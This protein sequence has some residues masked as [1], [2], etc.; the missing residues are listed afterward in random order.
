MFILIHYRKRMFL[1][2]KILFIKTKKD[3]TKKFGF[4]KINS[5][6]KQAK[7]RK[8]TLIFEIK[9]YIRSPKI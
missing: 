1:L 3:T 9:K 6:I 8:I 2:K 4:K 7:K 5:K